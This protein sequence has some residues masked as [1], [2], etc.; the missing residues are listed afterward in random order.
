[1]S[2]P[3]NSN[4][5][6]SLAKPWPF[7]ALLAIVASGLR[8]Y[9]LN[10][11]LWLDEVSA[12]RGYR[13]PFL[14]TITTFPDFF[15][16]P[17]YE[18][19]A[20]G[21][22]LVFGVSAWSIRLPA[23]LF[24]VAGVLVFYKLARRC[25][26]PSSGELAAALLAVSYHHIFFSQDARGYTTYL[27]FALLST[28][29]LLGLLDKMR[30]PLAAGYVAAIALATYAHPFGV[31][32]LLGHMLVALVVAWH[33]KRRHVDDATTV[34][35]II[36]IGVLSGLAILI[37]FAPL[38]IDAVQYAFSEARE[39]GHGRQV[40]AFIPELLEGLRAGFGGW[41]GVAIGVLVAAVGTLDL[42]RRQPA[43]FALLVVPIVLSLAAMIALGAGVHPRYFLLALPIGYLVGTRGLMLIV[44]WVAKHVLRLRPKYVAGLNVGL[45]VVLVAAA[46]LPLR[47]YYR[48]PKQ[49]FL[50]AM[51]EIRQLAEPED[52]VVAA[53]HAAKA[54][55]LFYDPEYP[56]AD[57]LEELL[58]V[59]ATGKRVW[60][61]VTLEREMGSHRPEILQHLRDSYER[62][63]YLPGT[64]GDG[65]MR[66]YVREATP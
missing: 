39:S 45:G 29:L 12:L 31:F 21:S 2:Q 18:L 17:L 26:G 11:Q 38:I 53:V 22:L 34:G 58:A 44:D 7:V 27:F 63:Q 36:G 56:T 8:F 32:L 54:M 10:S 64:V 35:Q 13:K 28:E 42:L 16:N 30:R 55:R 50:G 6:I 49:D 59:E 66:I 40:L 46:C 19:M 62:V 43:A 61:M 14:E 9:Q 47:R 3:L 65:A 60:V 52:R 37:L 23:A 25:V 20:H 1:M 24:G 15:P 33:R 51:R 48:Y 57:E 5:N 41:P 4:E